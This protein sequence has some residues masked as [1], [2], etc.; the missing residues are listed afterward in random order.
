[1]A[2]SLVYFFSQKKIKK[3]IG[4]LKKLGLNL[5][6]GVSLRKSNKLEGRN[7]VL[8]GE[9]QSFSRTQAQK[10]ITENGGRFSSSVSKNTD[11]VLVGKNP[12]SKLDKAKKIGIEVIDEEKFKKLIQ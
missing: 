7:F 6:E 3:M 12:G 4:E 8:T 9:L 1:M 2:E 11:F 5:K 10:I